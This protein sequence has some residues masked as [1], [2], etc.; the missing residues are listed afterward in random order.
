MKTLLTLEDVAQFAL[1]IALFTLLDFAWWLYPAWLLSPDLGMLG[2]LI[3]PK[4]GAVSYNILHHKGVAAF[5]GIAG[6]VGGT[7]WL[8]FAGIILFGHSAMDRV[9]GYGLKYEDSFFHT[10]LGQIGRGNK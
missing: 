6:L 8:Q 3:S 5:I 2:Y 9:F 7:V 10:H 1:S 4:V